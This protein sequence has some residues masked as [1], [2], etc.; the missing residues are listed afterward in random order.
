LT[1]KNSLTSDVGLL[2]GRAILGSYLAAHGAQKLFGS[3]E[4]P[5]IDAVAGGFHKLGL[6]PGHVMARVAAVSELG[7]GLLTL[8]G[9]AY[10]LGPV[11]IAGTMAVASTTH[12]ANGPFAMKQ[13]YEL[14]LTNLAAAL[15]L[16][17]AGPGRFSVDSIFGTRLPKW[18]AAATLAGA[19]AGSVAS[20]RML[21][22]ATQEEPAPAA[23]EPPA[24]SNGSEPAAGS[25]GSE[26]DGTD[27]S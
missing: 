15:A 2:A 4:G 14:P 5:G 19:V 16:A 17:V 6:K 21:L 7:G 24:A 10:P 23:E 18:M 12:R 3:F 8:T 11:A 27:A 25:D 22:A 1:R 13:G 20:I 26:P 9:A